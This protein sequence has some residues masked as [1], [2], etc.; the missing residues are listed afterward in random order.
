MSII[1]DS[2]PPK[3]TTLSPQAIFARL[4]VLVILI[5]IFFAIFVL[6]WIFE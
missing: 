1:H 6:P 5:G 2:R 4:F 3:K